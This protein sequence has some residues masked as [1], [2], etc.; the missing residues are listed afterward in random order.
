MSS[1]PRSRASQVTT[2]K[3]S[4]SPKLPRSAG[5]IPTRPSKRTCRRCYPRVV[6]PMPR[7]SP[8]AKR[9]PIRPSP[10]GG[11]IWL[12]RVSARMIQCSS[13]ARWP[14]NLRSMAHGLPRSGNWKLPAIS[15]ARVSTIYRLFRRVY[16][17]SRHAT[18]KSASWRRTIVRRLYEA[19]AFAA[20]LVT[21]PNLR[22]TSSRSICPN[23]RSR[24]AAKWNTP[25][26]SSRSAC[27]E[28]RSRS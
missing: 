12:R 11:D 25:P 14:R 21:K 18:K 8:A 24:P 23:A 1:P 15:R 27:V 7:R 22:G 10:T 28:N 4:I 5:P 17:T 13:I 3:P 16:A 20:G 6:L 26:L 9:A 19:A 2:P